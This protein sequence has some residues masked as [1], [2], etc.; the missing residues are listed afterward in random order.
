MAIN[1]CDYLQTVLNKEIPITQALQVKVKGWTNN[2]LKLLL[3]L[4]P[5]VNH[6]STAFG[7]SLYCGAVLAGW[8]WMHLRL[9]ELGIEDA[10][11]V[12]QD[13]Q[14]SYPYPV[15]GDAIVECYPPDEE[16]WQKFVRVFE[17][18]SKGRLSLDTSIIYDGKKAVIF[19]GQFVVYCD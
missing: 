8:G 4:Q 19:K 14:I 1:T 6:L 11:I 18:R 5:N 9:K 16:S 7:G 17:R 12:I 10:H 13:G 15:L 3:P 2:Q